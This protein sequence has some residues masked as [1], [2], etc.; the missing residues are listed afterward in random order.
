MYAL[1]W[2]KLWAPDC[3]SQFK[4]LENKCHLAYVIRC[5]CYMLYTKYFSSAIVWLWNAFYWK[6][7]PWTSSR[8]KTSLHPMYFRTVKYNSLVLVSWEGE[9]GARV[10]VGWRLVPV[11]MLHVA[12]LF[13]GLVNVTCA[14]VIRLCQLASRP[15]VAQALFI[16]QGHA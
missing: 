9:H 16:L 14:E 13:W 5:C 4:R 3:V 12:V 2:M 6:N 10:S 11:G 8:N 1:L 15:P 7:R